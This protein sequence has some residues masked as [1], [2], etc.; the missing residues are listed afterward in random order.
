MYK[1]DAQEAYPIVIGTLNAL[2]EWA[3]TQGREG[4]NLRAKVSDVRVRATHLIQTDTLGPPLSDCFDFA[5]T[6]G[7]NFDQLQHVRNV[8]A[9]YSP[10]LVG[11]I[12]IKDSLIQFALLTQSRVLAEMTFVSRQDVE[13]IKGLINLSFDEIEDNLADQMDAMTYRAMISLHAAISFFLIET[14]RPL[15][16]MLNFRF[17]LPLPTLALAQRLYYD[18]GRADELRRENKIVHPAF[19]RSYGRALSS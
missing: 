14:A 13:R 6:S 15:P 8:A 5:Y 19:A 10:V 16:Q 2:L 11:A 12:M 3:P 17:N 18:A 1:D 4:A 9:A 7:I